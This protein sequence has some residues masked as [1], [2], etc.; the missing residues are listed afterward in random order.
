MMVK[1]VVMAWALWCAWSLSVSAAELPE[2]VKRVK[3]SIVG[4]GTIE[5]TRRPPGAFTGTGFVV[6]DGLHVLTSAHVLPKSINR[7][8]KEA[9]AVLTG[10][11]KGRVRRAHLVAQDRAHDVAL[12]RMEGAPLPALRL[13]ASNSVQ[14]GELFAFTGFPIGMVLGFKPVTHRGIVSAIT[15]IAIPR[16]ST[17]SLNAASVRRLASPYDVFQLDATA[18]PG[19]SGSPL[20]RVDSGE[21]VGILNM[22]FV[23][24]SKENVLSHP[25]GISY[26]I[27]IAFARKLLRANGL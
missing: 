15:P 16:T 24:Q 10:E 6:G 9:M 25:S 17:R 19:N 2:T 26:A 11:G 1:R 14:E 22:V 7:S 12:L 21:V 23:K 3:Q 5:P 27:P 8:R 18:Y 13:G 20:Y 4:V